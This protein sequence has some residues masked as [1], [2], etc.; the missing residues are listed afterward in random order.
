MIN[1]YVKCFFIAT[2]YKEFSVKVK[3][4]VENKNNFLYL[5]CFVIYNPFIKKEF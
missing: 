2:F 5:S 1:I 4:N 3:S